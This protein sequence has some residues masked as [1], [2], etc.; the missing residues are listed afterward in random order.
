MARKVEKKKILKREKKE[1]WKKVRKCREN[2]KAKRFCE[3]GETLRC[4]SV[5]FFLSF[6]IV[7]D[8]KLCDQ[9][10]F[11]FL[12]F[13]NAFIYSDPFFSS[14]FFNYF[15]YLSPYST[16]SMTETFQTRVTISKRHRGVT[17]SGSD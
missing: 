16:S 4:E 8:L 14:R 9:L 3:L 6:V 11:L 15:P 17:D 12:P 10:R 7:A 5:F 1:K 2:E 13:Q